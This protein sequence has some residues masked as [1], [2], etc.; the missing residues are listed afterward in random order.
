MTGK[1]WERYKKYLPKNYAQLVQ[2]S[3]TAKGF[4]YSIQ[5][6]KDVRSMRTKDPEMQ[7]HV[8]SAIRKIRK[9]HVAKSKR[10][11]LLKSIRA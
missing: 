4:I 6:I 9:R 10:L 7:V 1:A 11:K 2:K 3:L 5:Q 8:W